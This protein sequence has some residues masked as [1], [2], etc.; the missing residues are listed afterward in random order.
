MNSPHDT[1]DTL[2]EGLARVVAVDS[3][4]VWLTAEQ[5]A[6]CG[7][8]ATRSACG[9]G[10]PAAKTAASWRVSRSLGEGQA[11]LMLGDTVRVGVDRSALIRA[12]LTAYALPLVTMLFAASAMQSA[13]DALAIAAAL[14]GLIVGVAAARMLATRWRNALVPVVLGR[15]LPAAAASCAPTSASVHRISIPVVHKRSL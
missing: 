7:S 12:S 1:D 14:V 11:P 2:I 13:G 8:C 4:L 6:A 9:S 15:A 10:S 5:P 3:A